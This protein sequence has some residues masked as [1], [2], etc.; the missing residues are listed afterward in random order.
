M[1]LAKAQNLGGPGAASPLL[2]AF[3]ASDLDRPEMCRTARAQAPAEQG[4]SVPAVIGFVL[5]RG[6]VALDFLARGQIEFARATAHVFAPQGFTPLGCPPACLRDYMANGSFHGDLLSDHKTTT[7]SLTHRVN[8]ELRRTRLRIAT[9]LGF[10]S[11][12]SEFLGLCRKRWQLRSCT[13]STPLPAP[14]PLRWISGD[15][16]RI[17]GSPGIPDGCL[18]CNG[19]KRERDTGL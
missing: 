14:F 7:V 11:L 8:A 17:V 10:A 5:R 13:R 3:N 12:R 1:L 2:D 6:L 18:R 16:S 4:L 9:G 19:G 15:A